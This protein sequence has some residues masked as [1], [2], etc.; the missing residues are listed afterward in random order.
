MAGGGEIADYACTRNRGM[1]LADGACREQNKFVAEACSDRDG[2]RSPLF[3]LV[4]PLPN[5]PFRFWPSM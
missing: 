1:S 5:K 3:G 2:D 4:C